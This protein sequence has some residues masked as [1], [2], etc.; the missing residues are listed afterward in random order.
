MSLSRRAFLQAALVATYGP[1]LVTGQQA[2]VFTLEVP[3]VLLF[4]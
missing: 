4:S 2:S 3:D 1:R